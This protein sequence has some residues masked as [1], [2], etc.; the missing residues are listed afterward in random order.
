[1]KVLFKRFYGESDE[2]IQEY[3]QD[4]LELDA[5]IKI[6]TN[7]IEREDSYSEITSVLIINKGI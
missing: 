7:V 1:M 6:T 2:T 3:I 4:N 5:T